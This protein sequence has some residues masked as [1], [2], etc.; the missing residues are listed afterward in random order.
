VFRHATQYFKQEMYRCCKITVVNSRSHQLSADR[1]SLTPRV[2]ESQ[3]SGRV[4]GYT[5]MCIQESEVGGAGVDGFKS[6]A[7]FSLPRALYSL[8]RCVFAHQV[9]AEVFRS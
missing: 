5:E 9:F 2:Y 6:Y 3:L 4:V 7:P 8:W 1:S